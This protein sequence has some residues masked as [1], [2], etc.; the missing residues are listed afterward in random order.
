[1]SRLTDHRGERCS[2]RCVIRSRLVGARERAV[3]PTTVADQGRQASPH[4]ALRSRQLPIQVAEPIHDRVRAG[5]TRG[6]KFEIRSLTPFPGPGFGALENGIAIMGGTSQRRGDAAGSTSDHGE[7][8]GLFLLLG[9]A[10]G[11]LIVEP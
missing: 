4:P 2:G 8:S 5:A 11:E 9:A 10:I 3:A 1:M 7:P 6:A